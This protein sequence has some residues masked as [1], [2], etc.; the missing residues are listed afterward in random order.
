MEKIIAYVRATVWY[1]CELS[2]ENS[3]RAM[4]YAVENNCSLEEAINKLYSDPEVDDFCIYDE[5]TESDFCTDEIEKA[6][7]EEEEDE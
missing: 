3:E 4:K 5:S 1:T 6:W 2:E 7:I